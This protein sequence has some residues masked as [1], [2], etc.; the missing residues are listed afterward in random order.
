[1][2][3]PDSLSVSVGS[4]PTRE[5]VA[6]NRQAPLPKEPH[7][8]K[9]E[10]GTQAAAI[11]FAGGF[12]GRI[13]EEVVSEPVVKVVRMHLKPLLFLPPRDFG[14]KQTGRRHIGS[15]CLATVSDQHARTLRRVRSTGR[16]QLSHLRSSRRALTQDLPFDTN[17]RLPLS[18][19]SLF[20]MNA[21]VGD[22]IRRPTLDS[23]RKCG[24]RSL[25]VQTARS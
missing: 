25:G 20:R 19:P 16:R 10:Q 8:T 17:T 22:I 24:F 7:S 21:G 6:R 9:I 4:S 15:T 2:K 14:T 13:S 18:P 5:F 11:H 12:A 3:N 1:L 23:K